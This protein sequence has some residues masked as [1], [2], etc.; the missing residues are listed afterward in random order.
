MIVHLTKE[1]AEYLSEKPFWDWKRAELDNYTIRVLSG[2]QRGYGSQTMIRKEK[3]YYDLYKKLGGKI[4][5]KEK[6]E[7]KN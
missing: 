1:E 7:R 4:K 3:F 5:R 6:N 2:N